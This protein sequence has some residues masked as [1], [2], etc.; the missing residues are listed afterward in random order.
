MKPYKHTSAQPLQTSKESQNRA[1][2]YIISCVS[3]GMAVGT[4]LLL[5]RDH[6]SQP[7]HSPVYVSQGSSSSTSSY[8]YS[9]PR[10]DGR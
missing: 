10:A 7:T 8:F 1:W 2:G 6:A 4:S 5:G 9:R 3:A